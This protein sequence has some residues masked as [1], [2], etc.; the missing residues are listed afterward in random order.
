MLP[1]DGKDIVSLPSGWNV[2]FSR[3]HNAEPFF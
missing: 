1:L 2:M 3:I